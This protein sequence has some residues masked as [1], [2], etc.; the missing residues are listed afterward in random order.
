[1]SNISCSVRIESEIPLS[2]KAKS[3]SVDW[4][5]AEFV[6]FDSIEEFESDRWNELVVDENNRLYVEFQKLSVSEEDNLK[7]NVD[8]LSIMRLDDYSGEINCHLLLPFDEEEHDFFVGLQ[9]IF[10][11]GELKFSKVTSE[12]FVENKQRKQKQIELSNSIS[13]NI[14][15]R[16]S[17]WFTVYSIYDYFADVFFS[18]V[19]KFINLQFKFIVF[20]EKKLRPFQ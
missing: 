9:L 14:R 20:L 18:I 4:S 12:T 16:S 8:S 13:S 6:S 3:L 10:I 19:V 17:K 11:E 1:M 15:M 2:Q 7:A 5:K